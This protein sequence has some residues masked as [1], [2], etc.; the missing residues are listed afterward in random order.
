MDF[1][2][3]NQSLDQAKALTI[4]TVSGRQLATEIWDALRALRK[5]AE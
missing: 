3:A 1:A 5:Q 4:S 2:Q